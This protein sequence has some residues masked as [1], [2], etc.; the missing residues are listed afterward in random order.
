MGAVYEMREFSVISY[1]IVWYL[2]AFRVQGIRCY[3][4]F[5][6]LLG[7]N[8]GRDKAVFVLLRLFSRRSDLL[9]AFLHTS[10]RAANPV[11]VFPGG[12][13]SIGSTAVSRR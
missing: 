10:L 1:L 12:G 11:M 3:G 2:M 8:T 7:L 9:N 13:I 4:L 6:T 5:V